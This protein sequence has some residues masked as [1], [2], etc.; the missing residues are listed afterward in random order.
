M[1]LTTVDCVEVCTLTAAG[2]NDITITSHPTVV[3]FVV[4]GEWKF[5]VEWGWGHVL[6]AITK[7]AGWIVQCMYHQT[8][9][10]VADDHDGGGLPPEEQ[11]WCC[12]FLSSH[13]HYGTVVLVLTVFPPSAQS[14]RRQR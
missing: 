13:C 5:V 4:S 1:V 12:Y 2:T 14:T 9:P 11:W 3:Y 8:N 6:L 7:L 10:H